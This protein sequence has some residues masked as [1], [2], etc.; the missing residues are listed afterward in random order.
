MSQLTTGD[1]VTKFESQR[2][3][4][5][6]SGVQQLAL[7]Q[8]V[9]R[10]CGFVLVWH[11]SQSQVSNGSHSG[12]LLALAT[13]ST[14]NRGLLVAQALLQ[15]TAKLVQQANFMNSAGELL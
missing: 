8:K 7:P 15:V 14:E 11:Q 1:N 10:R 13:E 4:V 2:F 12:I 5:Q 6:L 9:R 3:K